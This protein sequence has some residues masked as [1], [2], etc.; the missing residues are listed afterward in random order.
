MTF[1]YSQPRNV[2]DRHATNV[3]A[4][5]G[6][7]Y[8]MRQHGVYMPELHTILLN[9]AHTREDIEIVADAF[10]RSLVAMLEDGF[11]VV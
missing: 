7:A 5:L 2:R 9:A 1:S 4:N 3:K 10:D 8:Y 11:F 6:L